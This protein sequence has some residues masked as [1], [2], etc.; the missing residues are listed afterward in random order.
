MLFVTTISGTA[1]WVLCLILH[2]FFKQLAAHFRYL[3]VMIS[4]MI[5][6]LRKAVDPQQKGLSLQEPATNMTNLSDIRFFR[7]R[8]DTNG[9]KSEMPLDIYPRS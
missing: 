8:R 6:S 4:R 9:R 2:P 1:A 3:P 7:P 5:L